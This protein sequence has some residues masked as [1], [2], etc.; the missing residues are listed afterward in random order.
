M[1]LVWDEGMYFQHLRRV[2]LQCTSS[3]IFD[4][5]ISSLPTKCFYFGFE[6]AQ[7]LGWILWSIGH[8]WACFV[9]A[10]FPSRILWALFTSLWLRWEHPTLSANFTGLISLPWNK[11][12]SLQLTPALAVLGGAGCR[13]RCPFLA[14]LNP[15][16]RMSP[17]LLPRGPQGLPLRTCP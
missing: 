10:A 16:H 2:I 8:L 7:L 3:V 4:H 6:K 9:H 11:T 13:G 17:P 14:S 12:T 1:L 5:S 15:H